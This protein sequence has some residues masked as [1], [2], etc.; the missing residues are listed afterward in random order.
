MR[1]HLLAKAEVERSG[2][3][4]DAPLAAEDVEDGEMEGGAVQM[5]E[6]VNSV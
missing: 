4:N 2:G 1:T 5:G 6:T 3:V